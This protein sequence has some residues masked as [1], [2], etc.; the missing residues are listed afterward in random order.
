[1]ILK[2]KLIEIIRSKLI[3]TIK[4]KLIKITLVT[5]FSLLIVSCNKA[6][7]HVIYKNVYIPQKCNISIPTRQKCLISNALNPAEIF[8]CMQYDNLY[9]DGYIL[10][11]NR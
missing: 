2:N 7:P 4:S 3:K 5:S 8:K 11:R 9:T 1:M 10:V 6:L